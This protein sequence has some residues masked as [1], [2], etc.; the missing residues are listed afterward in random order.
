MGDTCTLSGTIIAGDGS[1]RENALV[2]FRLKHNGVLQFADG[3][4]AD[5]TPKRLRSASDGSFSFDGDR[6]DMLLP[7]ESRW[8]IECEECG[9]NKQVNANADT[10]DVIAAPNDPTDA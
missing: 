6:N 9:F 5:R 2:T 10:L 8:L 4:L 1:P 3:R 7:P